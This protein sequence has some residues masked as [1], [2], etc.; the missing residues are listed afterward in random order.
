MITKPDH[1]KPRRNRR[2]PLAGHLPSLLSV[3]LIA[4]LALA[5]TVLGSPL[6]VITAP[7]QEG[8]F[9]DNLEAI[10]TL[11]ANETAHLTAP[12]TDVI[13]EVR[14]EDGQRVGK[15]DIL[16]VM[17]SREQQALLE[18][19]EAEVA[20]AERQ[21]RRSRSLAD[22]GLESQSIL[23]QRQRDIDAARARLRAVQSRLSD[24]LVVAP[25][26][27]VVGLRQV[28]VGSLLAPGDPVAT[29]HDDTVMKLDFAVPETL[30]RLLQPGASITARSPAFADE[31]FEGEVSS[32]DNQVDPV[33]RA[34]A[35]RA[36]VPNKE[37]RLRPGMM[38]TVRLV[39]ND[40]DALIIPEE[41][42]LPEG[43]RH[44]VFVALEDGDGHVAERREVRVGA[45]RPGEVEVLEGLE[46]DE[47]VIS[48]G[49]E[50]LSEGQA[51]RPLNGEGADVP[52][53][54]LLR[55]GRSG[56]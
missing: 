16:L 49:G 11:R 27:G 32:I 51:V 52:L 19:A 53:E 20:E 50:R 34:I 25:F 43:R 12:V 22:Q 6:P 23:D 26:D 38:M 17:T 4:L 42:L 45:R 47:R 14:F 15:G 3:A 28:S 1:P 35:V 56:Q 36:L 9:S 39:A 13:A 46:A 29:L 31:L 44:F 5:Q 55:Q 7:V 37:G 54:E 33:T 18:E 8:R 41:A 2:K 30:L 10:G 21:F 40:R 24:R 48:H